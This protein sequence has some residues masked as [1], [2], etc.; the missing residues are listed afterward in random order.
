[1]IGQVLNRRK[2][3]TVSAEY[4]LNL[5]HKADSTDGVALDVL[6]E[7]LLWVY[8]EGDGKS[9]LSLIYNPDYHELVFTH[10]G[11][12]SQVMRRFREAKGFEGADNA[13]IAVWEA[14]SDLHLAIQKPRPTMPLNSGLEERSVTKWQERTR[15]LEHKLGA[16]RESTSDAAVFRPNEREEVEAFNVLYGFLKDMAQRSHGGEVFDQSIGA[17]L[18]KERLPKLLHDLADLLIQLA[19]KRATDLLQPGAEPGVQSIA[20]ALSKL[21][22]PV[23]RGVMQTIVFD[24]WLLEDF[25]HE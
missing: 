13:S 14:L 4:Y 22:T 19:G 9:A 5:L 8:H 12:I 24:V 6:I 25:A 11:K 23:E 3:T 10:P 20:E 17:R 16:V 7:G 15:Q 18:K 21:K 2:Q 1:M